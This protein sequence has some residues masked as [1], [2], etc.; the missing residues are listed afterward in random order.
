[1]IKKRDVYLID[2]E[3]SIVFAHYGCFAHGL[4]ERNSCLHRLVRGVWGTN[5]FKELHD[6]HWIEEVQTNEPAS[7]RNM[8]IG[9]GSKVKFRSL[10][11][12][13]CRYAARHKRPSP[14]KMKC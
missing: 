9:H 11:T 7:D 8:P 1:M 14:T 12:R 2:D 13:T 5:D 4:S 6:R 10:F 3:A